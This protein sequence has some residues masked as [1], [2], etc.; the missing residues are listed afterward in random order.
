[1]NLYWFRNDLRL[2][3]NTALFHATQQDLTIAVFILTP[4]QWQQ[5]DDASCKVDL[6]LRQLQQLSLQLKQLNIPLLIGH[7]ELWQEIPDLLLQL[8]QRHQIKNIYWN[9]EYGINEMQRD[10][11]VKQRL[12]HQQIDV[13]EYSDRTLFPIGSIKNKNGEYYK[14]FSAFKQV[15]YERLDQAHIL[16]T[17]DQP[18]PQQPLDI[19]S[20]DIPQSIAGFDS[21]SEKRC[22]HWPVGE[23]IALSKLAH[24]VE[25]Q[26]T[27]YQAER[28]FPAIQ[29]TS[30]LS[31]YL[32][33]GI[34]SIR[35]CVQYIQQHHQNQ[36]FS[37]NNGINTWLNELLWR[38]FYQHILYGFPQVSR[39]QPFK[40]ETG[41][42]H[43]RNAP[44]DLH[45][46]QHGKTGFPLIDAAMRQLLDTG[47]MH[48][49][50]RMIVAMFLSKNLLIDWRLGEQWFMQHLID[51]DLAA[52][53]GGWQWSASTGT[54][55]VPYFRIFN[56]ISQSQK[57]DPN[58]DFIRQ[59]LPELAHL[60]S[61]T[62]HEPY[63][64]VK[65]GERLNYPQPIVD[66]KQSR[67]RALDAFKGI[68][69]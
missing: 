31:P 33:A 24:F 62:I 6:W 58:G 41:K 61:K 63:R 37:S 60:D 7:T 35:Q 14:V 64:Y 15:C 39:H 10:L 22:Q 5:H 25:D 53:N 2:N 59:W 40:A 42:I 52:N 36:L 34:L 23:D 56:P 66:L 21:I 13:Y 27:H 4:T 69:H 48:N 38:E 12:Q 11:A 9:Q 55:S 47:W 16:H 68:K 30:Q 3:D 1:M 26:I 54:D 44:E 20:D 46:W 49:R 29:G 65:V 50:L 57:F 8:C 51:G 32:N 28:D 18:A 19:A 67:Q 43:W 45:A 17:Y